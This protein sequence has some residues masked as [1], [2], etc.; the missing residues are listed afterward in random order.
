MKG[1]QD[2]KVV[3]NLIKSAFEYFNYSIEQLESIPKFSIVSFYSGIE[4]LFKARLANEHWSLIAINTD[5]VNKKDFDQG[6]F[7]SVGLETA[8]KRLNN[9][10]NE[11]L[12]TKS[13]QYGAFNALREHRNRIIHF[14]HD[15][16][17]PADDK[18]S[19]K[20]EMFRC[21][22]YMS[23]LIHK[24]WS[25]LFNSYTNEISY[26]K[27]RILE[28]QDYLQLKFA[29]IKPQIENWNGGQKFVENCPNCKLRSLCCD[30]LNSILIAGECKVCEIT[31]FPFHEH[32][33]SCGEKI[34][35]TIGGV[36]VC[37]NC[38]S[39]H[40]LSEIISN[41]QQFTKPGEVDESS[42]VCCECES[43]TLVL[44]EDNKWLCS[45]CC[46]EFTNE[47]MSQCEYCGSMNAHL[48]EESS[49]NGCHICEG[50]F[51]KWPD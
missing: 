14:H 10:C 38:G 2:K 26:F 12:D 29:E 20:E 25:E 34:K 47:E 17:S 18:R 21:W 23:Q 41:M 39:K 27:N 43:E 22:Y 16:S 8:N 9:L 49:L 19:A 1:S 7:N 15:I 24:N 42:G 48:P 6:R 33:C 36:E 28:V 45:K 5:K 4:L 32:E 37:E 35:I 51:H 40:D 11:G 13:I 50:S 31:L 30:N 46:A 44:T 3:N